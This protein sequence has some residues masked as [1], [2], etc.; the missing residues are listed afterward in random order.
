MK[1]QST[2]ELPLKVVTLTLA[3]FAAAAAPGY[4]GGFGPARLR[5]FNGT[6]WPFIILGVLRVALRH[7]LRPVAELLVARK[8]RWSARER[9]E[10]KDKFVTT[11]FKL[12]FFAASSGY[13]WHTCR[14]EPWW[15]ASLGGRATEGVWDGLGTTTAPPGVEFYVMAQ[16]AYA[17]HSLVFHAFLTH[18]RNDFWEMMLHHVVTVLLISTSWL[19]GLYRV[20]ALVLFCHDVPDFFVYLT[21]TLVDTRLPL[22]VTLT[23]YFGM[24]SSWCVISSVFCVIARLPRPTRKCH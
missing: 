18:R 14:G 21:K 15:P 23:G 2:R 10:K 13:A 17:W 22:A 12:G 16:L 20:G 9:E 5:A 3:L 24:V 6:V 7:L 8:A 11:A 1:A 19:S 4:L